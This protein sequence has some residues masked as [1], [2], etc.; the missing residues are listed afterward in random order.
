MPFVLKWDRLR[1]GVCSFLLGSGRSSNW[2]YY[3][4]KSRCNSRLL[5]DKCSYSCRDIGH[6]C[7]SA[8]TSTG[9]SAVGPIQMPS[10]R[11]GS[12]DLAADKQIA[13]AHIQAP[14]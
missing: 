13:H 10:S 11:P 14:A 8:N 7:Y 1:A 9:H 3:T 6:R 4:K 2:N 12:D 5:D